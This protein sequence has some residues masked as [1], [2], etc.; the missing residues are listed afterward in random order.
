MSNTQ[1]ICAA[2]ASLGWNTEELVSHGTAT[3]VYATAVGPKEAHVYLRF[4]RDQ[5]TARLS[6]DYWSEGRNALST[7]TQAITLEQVEALIDAVKSFSS[8]VDR[9][10]A[11]TYAMRFVRRTAG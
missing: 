5:L 9:I 1:H 11:G 8:N 4:A 10:V 6:G 7:C 2:L 3:K